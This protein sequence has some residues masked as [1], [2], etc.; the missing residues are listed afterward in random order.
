MKIL[1]MCNEFPPKH[2]GGIGMFTKLMAE[3]LV[4]QGHDV[5][6]FG[7]GKDQTE[8]IKKEQGVTVIRL[9]EPK[10]G[11]NPII[12]FGKT[13][14]ERN[15]YFKRLKVQTNQSKPDLIESYDWSGPLLF[16]IKG[17]KLIVRLHG[18]N[19]ANNDY[20]S[21][22]RS[23]L[24]TI[25]EKRALK[26]ADRIVSVSDHVA[27]QTKK[28][29]NMDF[30]YQTIYN[31]VD[32]NKF[33]DL[34]LTRDLNKIVFVGRMHDY[35]GFK[36]LFAAFNTVFA[37]NDSVHFDIICSIIESYKD[38]IM[39]L[40]NK[41]YH[42]RIHFIGRVENSFLPKKYSEANLSILPSLTE[43]FPII[44]LESMS[45][46]T[47]VIMSNQFS[48]RE[49]IEDGQ[50][51]FLVNV[52]NPTELAEGIL[53]AISNQDRIESMRPKV[54]DKILSHFEID[55]IVREN[56]KYYESI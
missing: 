15:K 25:I 8:T 51:G 44:P 40:V 50:D 55:R 38:K 14:I 54:I 6:V 17:V 12:N 22:K 45:C 21:K 39:T 18:S 3:K 30:E 43:A 29:F 56:I 42:D 49:I 1:Y 9:V 26:I 2:S 20:M 36:E 52:L 53:N 5:V 7:Y 34:K 10:Y 4:E 11:K 19:T 48:S 35:K 27:E 31:G 37:T 32:L 33:K 47:P 41:K 24:F 16:K 46:G 13:L 28:S 23:S